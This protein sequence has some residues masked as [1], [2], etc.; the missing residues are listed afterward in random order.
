MLEIKMDELPSVVLGK[1]REQFKGD[2]A[3]VNVETKPR[4][5]DYKGFDDVLELAPTGVPVLMMALSPP[6]MLATDRR[7]HVAMSYGNVV[8]RQHPLIPRLMVD[9]LIEIR[10]NPRPD[11][12]LVRKTL[13]LPELQTD[14]LQTIR[15]D[16][17]HA[18]NADLDSERRREMDARWMPMAEKLF[19]VPDLDRD[20]LIAAI[21]HASTG[22]FWPEPLAGETFD[23]V[24]CDV[25]GTLINLDGTIN[26][27]LY[28]QLGAMKLPVVLWTGGDLKAVAADL[29]RR[30]ISLPV[31]PKGVMRG[32]TVSM[33]IDDLPYDELLA[34]YCITSMEH[35]LP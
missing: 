9:A 16:L 8:C 35:R 22:Q 33:T 15:H 21:E 19:G 4:R 6:H 14:V 30:G 27:E 25:E 5:A 20:D 11:N 13:A 23:V 2:G 26:A 24:A 28:E 7:Y 17:G 1:L 31:L 32:V 18:Q 3:I 34:Q 10:E 12:L 29:R